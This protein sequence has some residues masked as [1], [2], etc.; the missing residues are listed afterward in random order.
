MGEMGVFAKKQRT[1]DGQTKAALTRYCGKH[2]NVQDMASGRKLTKAQINDMK[3]KRSESPESE[4]EGEGEGEEEE[5]DITKDKRIKMKKAKG[6]G[7]GK[8]PA[9]GKK[10]T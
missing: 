7:K 8:A 9:K 6:K 2:L 5:G 10:K 3:V 1:L 4:S